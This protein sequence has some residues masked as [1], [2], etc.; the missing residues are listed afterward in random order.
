[1]L[2]PRRK[3]P[4][5][6]SITDEIVTD[7]LAIRP[8]RPH[9]ADAVAATV[10]S[11]VEQI[12]GWNP[13]ATSDLVAQIRRDADPWHWVICR[14]ETGE[15]IGVLGAHFVDPLMIDGCEI[16]FWILDEFRSQGLMTEAVTAFV[17]RLA[18]NGVARVRASTAAT[19][20]AVQRLL[21]RAGFV[22]SGRRTITLPNGTVMDAIDYTRGTTG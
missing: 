18:L 15:V 2:T 5:L 14:I 19:N 12:N 3:R 20:V 6:A 11:E 17:E 22:E 9:D 8:T 16:G 1:M 7:R 4:R 21:P 13:G 10:T